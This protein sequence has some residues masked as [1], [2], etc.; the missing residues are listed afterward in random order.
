MSFSDDIRARH[1]ASAT[2]EWCSYCHFRY[3][4][5]PARA[6]D[7]ID[8]LNALVK[9]IATH[10][11]TEARRAIRAEV[12][13]ENAE[14]EADIERVARVA[15]ESHVESL[16]AELASLHDALDSRAET[17]EEWAEAYNRCEER[18]EKAKQA[19]AAARRDAWTE[20]Y[21]AARADELGNRRK[22]SP[23]PYAQRV[24]VEKPMTATNVKVGIQTF[25]LHAPVDLA[26]GWHTLVKR[27]DG[28]WFVEPCE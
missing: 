9:D 24:Y 19:L 10:A 27:A 3:P 12:H 11:D 8:R 20:G 21:L 4:C 25:P 23:N 14:A 2:T 18:A 15:A 22:A 1:A 6:A 17:C 7:E 28:T 26:P 13:A 5:T 16:Q